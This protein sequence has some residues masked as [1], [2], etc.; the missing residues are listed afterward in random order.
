MMGSADKLEQ[1]KRLR[2]AR[3]R[4][5][6]ERAVDAANRFGW[7]APTYH[8]HENG[9]RGFK[10][11]TALAYAKAF[12]VSPGWLLYGQ[13]GF[14]EAERSFASPTPESNDLVP[15]YNVHASAGHGSFIEE[16]EIAERLAFPSEYL[17]HVTKADPKNLAII[18]VK[19]DSMLPT[20]KDD[21]LV[22]LD[23]SKTDLSYDGLFVM[24]DGGNALLVKRITRASQ[25]D[26]ILIKS[27]N[28]AMYPPIER[29]L[30]EVEVVGKVVWMGVK[31]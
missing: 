30:S 28:A 11:D 20:L 26:F 27:D 2:E 16:E 15:V 13:P 31:V 14:E 9:S 12:K 29:H 3:E 25:K 17:R 19:G 4:A 8:G 10:K 24:R 18:G 5:G 6:F 22:M 21:D 23:T 1:A 7:A